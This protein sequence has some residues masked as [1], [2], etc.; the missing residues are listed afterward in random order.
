MVNDELLKWL[1]GRKI[2]GYSPD[3]LRPV[4]LDKGWDAEEVDKAIDRV[5]SEDDSLNPGP[6]IAGGIVLLIFASGIVWYQTSDF[7][8]QNKW[9]ESP[10]NNSEFKVDSACDELSENLESCT[11]YRC[12]TPDFTRQVVNLQGG[13]CRLVERTDDRAWRCDLNDSLK[14]ELISLYSDGVEPLPDSFKRN[15]ETS[16]IAQ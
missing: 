5:Y 13:G 16:N 4:L 8:T 12:E 9:I 14:E 15:C 2:Q 3:R 11:T 10:A 6:F 7:E 1:R